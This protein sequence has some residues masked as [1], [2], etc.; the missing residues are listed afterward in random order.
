MEHGNLTQN[1][2]NLHFGPWNQ[3]KLLWFCVLSDTLSSRHRSTCLAD[4]GHT[5][6]NLAGEKSQ[7][8]VQVRSEEICTQGCHISEDALMASTSHLSINSIE[9]MV[10]VGRT[11]SRDRRFCLSGHT[12]AVVNM[13]NYL[14][15]SVKDPKVR[16]GR[17]KECKEKPETIQHVTASCT[18]TTSHCSD[19]PRHTYASG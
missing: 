19:T 13:R 14:N 17:C 8:S 16:D 9:S 1:Q 18:P 7:R 4:L 15:Y 5:S 3:D 12:R 10:D 11:V 2:R 6:L